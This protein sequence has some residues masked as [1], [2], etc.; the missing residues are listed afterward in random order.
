MGVVKSP[1]KCSIVGIHGIAWAFGDMSSSRQNGGQANICLYS[2]DEDDLMDYHMLCQLTILRN[3][4]NNRFQH[5]N[6][7]IH[8][9]FVLMMRA[10]GN[11]APFIIQPPNMAVIPPEIRYDKRYWPWMFLVILATIPITGTGI[12]PARSLGAAIIYNKDHAWDDQLH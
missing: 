5:S 3:Y 1:S 8:R 4:H 7:T 6:E 9:H 12:N 2:D 10:L 11:L